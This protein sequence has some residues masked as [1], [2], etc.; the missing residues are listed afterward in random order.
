MDSRRGQR[1]DLG[2]GGRARLYVCLS[3]LFRLRAGHAGDERLLG[4]R[5]PGRPGPQPYRADYLQVI[6]VS[7]TD[8]QTVLKTMPRRSR[9]STTA[10]LHVPDH[11]DAAPGSSTLKTINSL[12]SP[13]SFEQL[14]FEQL[15]GLK[16]KD[17]AE[18]S[19]VIADLPATVRDRLVEVLKEMKARSTSAT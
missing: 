18:Q 1:R 17:F 2:L 12:K 9:I 10:D 16:W 14:S 19:Y 11:W 7:E 5:R 4:G 6:G 8:A 3:D 15:A 13:F